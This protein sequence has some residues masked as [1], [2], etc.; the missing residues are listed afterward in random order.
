MVNDLISDSLVKIKNGY[1]AGN[2][3]VTLFY[4]KITEKLVT[5]LIN[6]NFASK[7]EIVKKDNRKAIIVS[8]IYKDKKPAV[9]DIVRVSKPSLRVYVNRKKIPWVFGGLGIC[10]IST[11][12]GLMTGSQARKN[13]LGGELICK[14]W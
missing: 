12:K 3:E 14:I 11:P 1:L 13:N 9:V 6:N 2:S 7:I 8:L 5:L 10:I 4:S